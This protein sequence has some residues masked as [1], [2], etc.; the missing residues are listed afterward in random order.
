MATEPTFDSTGLGEP[1]PTYPGWYPD[2][3]P[4][5]RE[6]YER[7]WNG[8]DWSAPWARRPAG[9]KAATEGAGTHTSPRQSPIAARTHTW[10]KVSL[11]YLWNCILPFA[12]SLLLPYLVGQWADPQMSTAGWAFWLLL[13]GW[14]PYAVGIAG[15]SELRKGRVEADDQHGTD[16]WDNLAWLLAWVLGIWG[17][18]ATVGLVMAIGLARALGGGIGL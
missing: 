6:G 17:G 8:W 11:L 16:G 3:D 7:Y 18:L 10:A 5:Y 13:A 9:D 1:D 2:P 15:K 14:G 4:G 12:L